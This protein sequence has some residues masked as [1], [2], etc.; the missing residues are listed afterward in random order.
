M[1]VE[2]VKYYLNQIIEYNSTAPSERIKTE[3][4]CLLKKK[5]DGV[6][7]Q[8]EQEFNLVIEVPNNVPPTQDKAISRLILIKYEVKVEAKVGGMHKNLVTTTPITIG[9]IP[10]TIANAPTLP[11]EQPVIFGIGPQV[12]G[13]IPSDVASMYSNLSQDLNSPHNHS[14]RSSIQLRMYPNPMMGFVPN[15]SIDSQLNRFSL[16]SQNS[17]AGIPYSPTAPP[18]PPDFNTSSPAQTSTQFVLNSPIR[19]PS[20]QEACYGIPTNFATSSPLQ[21]T[22]SK[23]VE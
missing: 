3:T 14:N 21:S 23:I 4:K 5:S 15:A 13:I 10:H 7:K 2:K 20:Y 19:P 12:P 11:N 17:Y 18:P 1:N 16:L 9:T 6:C 8:S 22:S